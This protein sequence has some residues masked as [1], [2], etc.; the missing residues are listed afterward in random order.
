MVQRRS[1]YEEDISRYSNIFLFASLVLAEVN[2]NIAS[3]EKL[4]FSHI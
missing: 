4:S 3:E 2:I 1:N